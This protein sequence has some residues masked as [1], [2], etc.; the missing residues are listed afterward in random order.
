MNPTQ[1]GP[2]EDFSR[3]PRQP[4]ADAAL[5]KKEGVDVLFAPTVEEIYLNGFE[6]TVVVPKLARYWEGEQ[7]PVACSTQVVCSW[8]RILGRGV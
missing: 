6:T 5:C 2:R 1:F 7:R 4:K 8:I 3:Y